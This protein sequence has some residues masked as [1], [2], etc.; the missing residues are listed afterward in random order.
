LQ[1]D[2]TQRDLEKKIRRL[3]IIQSNYI[4]WKGYFDIINLV[5][6]FIIFDEVQYS[7]NTWRNRNQIK[8]PAGLQW[9]TIPIEC[10]GKCK[11]KIRDVVVCDPK[12]N[13]KHWKTIV[14]NYSKSKFFSTYKDQFE[15]LYLGHREWHLSMIN[16]RFMAAICGIL[17]IKTKM[18]WDAEYDLSGGRTE[19]LA[20]LCLQT[21]T[22]IYLT[23]PSAKGY[24]DEDLFEKQGLKLEYMDYSGYKEYNQLY[25]PFQHE[26]SII[27]LIF[28]EGPDAV[29]YMK[30]FQ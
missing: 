7:K 24:L 25:P 27:D 4:P 15:D 20:N 8:T 18:T 6:E 30:S 10:K 13:V 21:G 23:G 11:Q 28:N 3:G 16:Y 12:W 22:Q 2:K 9:L 26:V 17:G 29:K 1:N 5:D 14:A 19:K